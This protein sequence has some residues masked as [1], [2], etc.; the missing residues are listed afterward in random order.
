MLN[1]SS[2][3]QAPGIGIL[4][5]GLRMRPD[6]L[7]LARSPRPQ[8]AQDFQGSLC[9]GGQG[10]ALF[11]PHAVVAQEGMDAVAHL[12]RAFDRLPVRVEPVPP[13]PGF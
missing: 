7:P 6:H 2:C 10:R 3:V 4:F 5:S 13:L 8:L 12:S 11:E 9:L 1:C